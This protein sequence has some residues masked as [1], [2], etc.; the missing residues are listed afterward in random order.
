MQKAEYDIPPDLRRAIQGMYR[1]CKSAVRRAY[2][3]GF[4]FDVMTGVRQG[5]VLSPLLFIL[6]MDQVLKQASM[7]V[8]EG[9]HSGTLAY[10]DDVGRLPPHIL[11]SQESYFSGVLL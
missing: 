5:S 11:Q 10:A 9:D 7:K 8:A 4:W 2:G 6:L 1:Q 3:E